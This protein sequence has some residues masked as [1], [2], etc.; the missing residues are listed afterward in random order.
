MRTPVQD[1][2]ILR[3][4]I[5]AHL[6]QVL[7]P[8]VAAGIMADAMATPDLSIDP[9]KF[10][11]AEHVGLTICA[12]RMRDVLDEL[13]PLHQAHWLETDK[14]RHGLPLAPAYDLMLAD[15]R[16]GRLLQF[17]AR[18]GAELVGNLRMY[19]GVSRHS[20]TKFATED[21]LYLAPK[22]RGGFTALALMRFAER[23]LLS[24][25]VREIRA[26]SKLV[27]NAGALM[28]RMGYEPVATQ[29]VKIFKES[30]HVC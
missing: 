6:G 27:N 5:G 29:Y 24:I 22:A 11:S 1:P 2:Y 26:D 15:E 25:G 3:Q 9:A 19:L 13:H 17:T 21:T 10:G 12:E 23:A 8:D 18:D 20:G 16:A 7:T 30:S 14:H 4:A 28:R